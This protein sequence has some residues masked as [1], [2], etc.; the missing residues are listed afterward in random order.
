MT[1]STRESRGERHEEENLSRCD[2]VEV[3][4]LEKTILDIDDFDSADYADIKRLDRYTNE[5][6]L[7]PMGENGGVWFYFDEQAVC[8]TP[9]EG[10]IFTT[11]PDGYYAMVTIANPFVFSV[12]RTWDYICLW[13]RKNNR[14]INPIDIGGNR[15]PMLVKFFKNCGN[16]FMQMYLPVRDLD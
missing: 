3:V 4:K 7:T 6:N 8:G 15:T 11:I 2:N 12:V 16:Q 14:A 1:H 10:Y 9:A 13:T 5:Y